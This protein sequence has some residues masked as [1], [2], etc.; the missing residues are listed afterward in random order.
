MTRK[1]SITLGLLLS[2][3]IAGDAAAQWN[4]ARYGTDRSRIYTTFGMDP[5]FVGSLGY[6]RVVT[7]K[8]HDFQLSGDVGMVTSKMDTRDFRARLGVQTSLVQWRDVHLT[9]SASFITRG[10]ENAIYKGLN[11]GA[12]ITGSLGVYRSKWFAAGEA[13]FDKAIVTHV[14]HSDWYREHHYAEA[15]DGWYIDTGGTWH[16]GLTGGVT[17]GR[18]ELM[19]RIGWHQTEKHNALMSP[20]YASLG[21]GFRL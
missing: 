6:G 10:T 7:V 19:G 3:G 15:K 13:G 11:F 2:A 5:A 16:G 18:A 4:V 12:D 20:M 17:L 9:G 21:V 8:R 1:M 14:T